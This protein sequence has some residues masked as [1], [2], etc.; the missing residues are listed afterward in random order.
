MKTT[1][2]KTMKSGL[3]IRG[4]SYYCPL[5]FQLDTYWNC[6]NECAH[7]YMRRLNR[8]WGWDLRPLDLE[9]FAHQLDHPEAKTALG[10]AIRARKTIRFGNKTDP[11]QTAEL[12]HEVSRKAVK[13][14]LE[15]N[16]SF[17]LQTMY[18]D[19]AIRD[20]DLFLSRTDLVSFMPIVSPGLERD[21]ELFERKGTTNP[22]DRIDDAARWQRLGF[23]VGINGEPFIPGHHTEKDFEEVLK[24]L[25]SAGLKSYN[26]YH[27]HYN[28]WVA[29]NFAALG[30]DVVKIWDLNQDAEWRKILR[31][32]IDLAKAYDITLGCPDFVNSGKYQE[33]TNTCCGMNVP[34]P[35]T[36]NVIGW[37]KLVAAGKS[38]EE[39]IEETW[40][41]IG[42]KE[43][44]AALLAGR[45]EDFYSLK[46]IVYE[47]EDPLIELLGGGT[48]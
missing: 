13:M 33:P 40:D 48:K 17:V 21:W 16:F 46:D 15:R 1:D 28:D 10:A 45:N 37:K 26:T 14:L 23:N 12:T 25:K 41:G 11:Y 34:N 24:L 9:A 27:L 19:N 30:L 36:F 3:S 47:D 31:R 20:D 2:E 35:C 38:P 4:D 18:T 8:T 29:K 42:E 5:S 22:L 7:C 43:F 6:E 44:G 32:L 39:A